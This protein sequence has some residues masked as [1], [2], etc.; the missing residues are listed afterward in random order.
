MHDAA[1]VVAGGRVAQVGPRSA[2]SFEPVRDTVIDARTNALI[3]GFVDLHCHLFLMG[4][5]SHVVAGHQETMVRY[6][7]RGLRN[8]AAWLDQG[9]TTTRQLGCMANL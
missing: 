6:I 8:A 7:A 5:K 9:V 4:G 1:V 2:V 3:P